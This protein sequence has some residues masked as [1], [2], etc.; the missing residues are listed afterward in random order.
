MAQLAGTTWNATGD[1]MGSVT[2]QFNSDG[3]M[4][5]THPNGQQA[6]NYFAEL[7]DG[8]FVIQQPKSTSNPNIV[9]VFSGT[10]KAGVGVGDWVSYQG[11]GNQSVLLPFTMAK[12]A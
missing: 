3:T 6:T 12:K 7:S 11:I 5:S 1:Q 4:L 10:H 8:T 2:F 9:V